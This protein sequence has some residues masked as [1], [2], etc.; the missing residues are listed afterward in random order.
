MQESP[1]ANPT[2]E[3]AGSDQGRRRL[4]VAA[5]HRGR[6]RRL[7]LAAKRGGSPEFEFSRATVVGFR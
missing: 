1:S 5:V 7:A 3:A 4:T 2:A 6:A